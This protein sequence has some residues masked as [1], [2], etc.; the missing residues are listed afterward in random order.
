MGDD[1]ALDRVG[2]AQ[3]QSPVVTEFPNVDGYD[4]LDVLGHGGMG[5]VYKARHERLNR[6]VALKMIRAGS[7]AKPE[8]LA[9]FNIEAE[10]IARLC[11]PNIIQIY[12]VGEVGGLPFVALEL[13]E[14][15]SLDGRL[16]NRPQPATAAASQVATLARA[17]DAAHQAGIVHRDL[18][19]ANVLYT[20][21]GIAKITDFGLAKRLEQDGHTET[22]QVLGSPNYI[23]PEQARGNAKEAG[24]PA[25]VYALGAIL[26]RML[27][28]RPPFQGPTPVET[29]M[30]VLHQEPLPP[31]RL[32]PSVPRDLE[33]ICLRCLAKE[34]GKRYTT[35]SALADDLDRFT[36]DRPIHARRMPLWERGLKWAHR[37]PVVTSILA[38]SGLVTLAV[39]A[40]GIWYLVH[41]AALEAAARRNNELTLATARD[42]VMGG[43][44][45]AAERV[46]YRLTA[47]TESQRRFVDQYNRAVELLAKTRGLRTEA[48]SRQAAQ[49]RYCQFLDKRNAAFFEDT[50]FG[51]LESNGNLPAIRR[52][53]LE[54]LAVFAVKG[55]EG[56][57]WQLAPLPKSLSSK[58][59]DEVIQGCYEMLL[60]L[61][62][63][64]ARPLPDE[65][66][67]PQ[68]QK[69]LE[70]LDRAFE[71]RRE[72]TRAYHLRRA[73]CLQ[74][75]NDQSAAQREL[76]AAEQV[77]PAGALDHFLSGVERY[78]SGHLLEAKRYFDEALRAD[79]SHFWS[80]CLHA[81][82]D[83]NA[84]PPQL[85]EA[86]AYLTG[87]LQSHS[88]LPWLY[89]LRGFASSQMGSASKPAA[90]ASSYFANAEADYQR[91]FEL[92]PDGKFRHA[93]LANRGLLRFQSGRLTDAISD[94]KQAIALDARQH[95]AYVTLAQ[96]YRY[97]QK[98]DAALE[99]LGKAIAL[100][101]DSSPL[102]RTRAL[103]I[104]EQAKLSSDGRRAALR[105]LDEVIRQDSPGSRELA[106][107]LATKGRILGLDN[108]YR[109]AL[110]ACNGALKINPDEPDALHCRAVAM[111][112]LEQYA[113]VIE[114]CDL[115]LKKGDLSSEL[116]ELRGLAKAKRNDF[117]GAIAD[118]T[119]ALSQRPGSATLL[120]RRGWAYLASGAASLA[121]SDFAA[122]IRLDPVSSDAYS[123][124]GS[125]MVAL[126]HAKEAATDAEES[127]RLGDL[128]P[129][130]IYNASRVL[131]QAAECVQ[132]GHSAR[133]RVA[134]E[135]ARSYQDRSLQLLAQSLR[136]MP[137][138]QR[139]VF[140]RDVVASDLA[141]EK[142]RALPGYS[143]LVSF[144]RSRT[145]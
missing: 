88:G 25:D 90:L 8:D 92:D 118:Y 106:K 128:E 7:L 59:K 40:A 143:R 18:K 85:A 15:G 125:A 94:L 76:V 36:A 122:A 71:L 139:A 66:A 48:A 117:S 41:R 63:A 60:V 83:L 79:P 73:A 68:A 53:S 108:Q 93:L 33:T 56:A 127:L 113:E 144:S 102:R 89:L 116:L 97:Q 107:D 138:E 82:C 23:P 52:S 86:K 115:Y 14:G 16:G 131:A 3:R 110:L 9:R 136:R 67:M 39:S 74:R 114:S 58:Q 55:S 2:H 54:A 105:D 132:E 43:Q 37:R 77:Q 120:T 42:D 70:I 17:I 99:E 1:S 119:L 130:L 121:R 123:G 142:I 57:T 75:A 98:L 84:R 111:I 26:Y 72:P 12:D 30:Q 28:G 10:V 24:A 78:N 112:K 38:L 103:W 81:I 104:L 19:P 109:E 45:G 134:L 29:V 51:A 35:A 65:S 49:D 5:V 69:A 140:C 80:Q 62:E 32:Q 129:R 135:L 141:F 101:P 87:C 11:H 126:G 95:T 61:A 44:L 22:G 4:L 27:T 13:L 124:R 6:L 20:R 31:S 34:P 21:D 47:V 50:Q 100:K 133:S 91:A 137:V 46:L 96:I 64:V 145:P